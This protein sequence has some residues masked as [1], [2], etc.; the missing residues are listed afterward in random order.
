MPEGVWSPD[1]PFAGHPGP[2]HTGRVWAVAVTP[3]G[4][5]IITGGDDG[6]ARVWD[7]ATGQLQII[8]TGHSG[9]V[10]SVA[11]TPDGRQIVT[12]GGDG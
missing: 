8:L 4:R 2:S 7:R 6:T 10:R 12:G 3:D 11:V 5:Q 9:R 1:E